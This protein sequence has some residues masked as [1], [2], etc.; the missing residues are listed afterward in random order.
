MNELRNFIEIFR[1]DFR[2]DVTYDNIKSHKKPGLHLFSEKKHFW[3][4]HRRGGQ[5]VPPAILGLILFNK[6]EYTINDNDVF[7]TEH[8]LESKN[9]K[10]KQLR[11]EV[12]L[13]S[14]QLKMSLWLMVYSVL[15]NR[16]NIVIKSRV[17]V[18]IE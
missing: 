1:K 6:T 7:V 13:L 11:K 3:K 12:K 17:K 15:S 16:I 8:G 10:K 14:M 18:Y 4:N 5:I 9:Q 2:K